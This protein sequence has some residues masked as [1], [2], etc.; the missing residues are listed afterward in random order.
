MVKERVEVIVPATTANLGPGFDCMGAALQLYNHFQFREIPAGLSIHYRG[1]DPISQGKDNL[2]YRAFCRAFELLDKPVPGVEIE[3]T[4][5][6]PLARG[7]GS[8]ATAIVGGLLGANAIG[9]LNLASETLLQLAIVLEGHPDNV[10]PALQGGCQLCVQGQQ[11]QWV[12]CPV[13]WHERIGIV[14]A[15]PNFKLSTQAAR[16]ILPKSVSLADAVFSSSHLGLLIRSLQSGRVDWLRVA[17]QD[18]LHQPA[19]MELIPGFKA[20]QE[21]ALAAG[22]YGVVI[23]GAGPTLL[24]FCAPEEREGVGAAMVSAWAQLGIEAEAKPLSLDWQGGRVIT[25]S[26]DEELSER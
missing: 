10:V 18:R 3:I 19:R 5:N 1:S 8:S 7:L 26:R 13:E 17:L 22:A 23:S 6:V 15:V 25:H 4:L 24:A 21:A 2:V 11:G 20:V 16:E 14:A 12:F 9:S